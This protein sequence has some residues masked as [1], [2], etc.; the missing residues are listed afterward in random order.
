MLRGVH[1]VT[2]SACAALCDTLCAGN[3][4]LRLTMPQCDADDC[5]C[6]RRIGVSQLGNEEGGK[7]AFAMHLLRRV[8]VSAEQE[9]ACCW[10]LA[11]L[12]LPDL[13]TPPG[14]S[15]GAL[16][17]PWRSQPTATRR[18]EF[19][20]RTTVLQS[21]PSTSRQKRDLAMPWVKFCNDK[22]KNLEDSEP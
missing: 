6:R 7:H 10:L 12:P 21:K 19:A 22:I 17:R 14:R 1:E 18:S 2:L 3:Q 13:A 8:L 15:R 16:R 20:Y 9:S 4:D 5:M 11:A